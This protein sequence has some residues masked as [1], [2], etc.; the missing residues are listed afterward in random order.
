MGPH[1]R[2]LLDLKNLDASAVGLSAGCVACPPFSRR[3]NLT[4]MGIGTTPFNAWLMIR[5]LRTLPARLERIT[6]TTFRMLEFLKQ[7]P[8]IEEVIFPLDPSFPQYQ[9]AKKQMKGA[10]G[11]I[12]IVMK[13]QKMQEIV[14]FCESLRHILMAVSWGGYESLALPKCASLLPEQF[15]ATNR[16]HR[17]IRFYFGL[18]EADYLMADINRAFEMT[19]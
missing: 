8:K 12:T 18:E 5:G 15:D 16:E 2:F 10:C 17:M 14:S 6:A 13:A 19:N 11:L 1:V 7:H 3:E 9:L 4:N